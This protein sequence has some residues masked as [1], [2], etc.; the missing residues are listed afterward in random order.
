MLKIQILY[1]LKIPY[2]HK[3][4]TLFILWICPVNVEIAYSFISKHKEIFLHI[5]H[6]VLIIFV[7][8]A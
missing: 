4:H 8:N 1:V 2:E 7:I 3:I 6:Y 5:P